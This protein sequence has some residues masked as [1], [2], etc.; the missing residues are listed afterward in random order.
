VLNDYLDDYA[1]YCLS[2]FEDKIQLSIDYNST[3][4]LKI[5]YLYSFSYLVRLKITR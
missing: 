5:R 4:V 3:I 1:V 2:I